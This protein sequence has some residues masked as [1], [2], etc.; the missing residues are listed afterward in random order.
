MGKSNIREIMAKLEPIKR[1]VT[2]DGRDFYIYE[3]G[4][5]H[6]CVSAPFKVRDYDIPKALEARQ[7]FED[8]M[9]KEKVDFQFTSLF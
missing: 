5:F 1:E 6:H 9:R 2:Q 8:K 7:W 3:N 4:K